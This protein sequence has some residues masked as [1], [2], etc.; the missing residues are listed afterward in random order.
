MTDRLAAQ[1]YDMYYKYPQFSLEYIRKGY[2]VGK[3]QSAELHSD[4]L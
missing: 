4:I 2:K 3:R 1:N